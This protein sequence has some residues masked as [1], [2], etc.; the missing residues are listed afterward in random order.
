[1]RRNVASSYTAN[2]LAWLSKQLAALERDGIVTRRPNPGGR[3][4]HWR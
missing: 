1:M 3:G 4:W 2:H